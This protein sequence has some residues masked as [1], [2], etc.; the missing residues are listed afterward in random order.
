V[1]KDFV[2]NSALEPVAT[3]PPLREASLISYPRM[4]G[5]RG[6][7]IRSS[8]NVEHGKVQENDSIEDRDNHEPWLLHAHLL[9]IFGAD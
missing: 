1:L 6:E 3:A 7:H 4:P 2:S 9:P 5:R 8:E